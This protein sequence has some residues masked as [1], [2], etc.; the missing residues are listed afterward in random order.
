MTNCVFSVSGPADESTPSARA[1]KILLRVYGT[2]VEQ[3]IKRDREMFWLCQMSQ[4]GVAPTLLGAFSNGRFEQY[5]D[6]VTL[7]KEEIRDPETSRKIAS[8]L[9]QLHILVNSSPP[10]QKGKPELW[11]KLRSWHRIASNALENMREKRPEHYARIVAAVDLSS[12]AKEIEVLGKTLKSLNS[13]IVFS[14]NDLQYGNVLRKEK[15]GTIVI[16]DYEYSGINYRGYDIANHFCEWAADYHCDTPHL[17]N[18]AR[19]PSKEEQINF[20]SAYLDAQ[21]AAEPN[22]TANREEEL[23]SIYKEVNKFTLCSNLLWGLWGVMQAEQSEIDFDFVGYALERFNWYK[24]SK[25]SLLA[26]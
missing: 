14:H 10:E 26:L 17:M 20:L 2:G 18:P 1:P 13:P 12:M 19:Y 4:S 11:R 9:Y 16:V 7:T 3:F 5:L 22:T 8:A 15:D 21:V 24:S 23:E 25:E 6:S